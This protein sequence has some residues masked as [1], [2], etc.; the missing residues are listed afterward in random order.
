MTLETLQATLNAP[1]RKLTVHYLGVS[2]KFFAA[3]SRNGKREA[4]A[5]GA[6]LEGAVTNA[7]Y[8]VTAPKLKLE[9]VR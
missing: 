3:I 6:S 9:L 5:T 4:A 2:G 7:L 1:G 8:N